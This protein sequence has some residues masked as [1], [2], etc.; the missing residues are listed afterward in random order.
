MIKIGILDDE[1]IICETIVKYLVDLGYQVGD[2]ATDF[3][4]GLALLKNDCPDLFLLDIN[5]GGTKNGIDFAQYIRENYQLPLIFISS[6]SDR[7]TLAKATKIKPNGYLVKPFSKEDLYTSIET[8]L[9]HFST[10]STAL[11]STNLEKDYKLL[12]EAFF[13]KQGNLYVKIYFKDMIY[14]KSEGVYAEIM[15]NSK[16]YL[17]RESLKNLQRILP[18][19]DFFQI[20]RSY[21]VNVNW[22][23]AVNAEFVVVQS[24]ILPISRSV[25]DAFLLKLNVV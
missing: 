19:T 4:E 2:Y 7:D 23:E 14:I 22:I 5:I 15:T 13:I 6:Y 24:E 11:A 21:I 18:E 8:A 10:D 12:A 1:V 9:S 20:H 16:K 17:I 25:R 3:E